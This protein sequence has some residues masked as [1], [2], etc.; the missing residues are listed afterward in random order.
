MTGAEP[1]RVLIADDNAIIRQGVR[2]LLESTAPDIEVVAEAVTGREAI[3]RARELRPTVALLDIRMPVLDGVAAAEVISGLAR[4]LMLTYSDDEPMVVGAIRAGAAGYLVHGRFQAPELEAAIRAVAAGQ[5]AISPAVAPVVLRALRHQ[6]T[7]AAASP[8]D[9]QLTEREHEVMALIARGHSNRSI[10]AELVIS[11]KTVKNHIRH[12][13]EKLGVASRTQAIAQWLGV[14]DGH[15]RLGDE[16]GQIIPLLVLV[17]FSVLAIGVALFAVGQASSL[18]AQGQTAA[19]AGAL[20][21]AKEA[22][23]ESVEPHIGGFGPGA[24]DD[25]RVRAAAADAARRNGGELT[26]YRRDGYTVSVVV[27]TRDMVQGPPAGSTGRRAVARASATLAGYSG[28]GVSGSAGPTSGAPAAGVMVPPGILVGG[29]AFPIQPV[30]QAVGPSGWSLDQGVDVSTAGGACGPA[31]VEVAVTSGTIVEEGI[32]GFGPYAPVLRIDSGPYANWYAYYGHA[33][34]ALV[35]VGTHVRAGQPIAEV[36]CGIVGLSSGPHIE[37]GLTPP[38]QT[39]CCPS[40][41]ETAPIAATLLS[42]IYAH[43]PPGSAPAVGGNVANGADVAG[44][45]PFA[46]HLVPYA[47]P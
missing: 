18:A 6:A 19:D 32:S 1:I 41:G 9:G 28:P 34:P 40:S 14:D 17:L 5:T 2:S 4:V 44:V 37:F 43:S 31:A 47:G 35:P 25:V 27:R 21:G 13:Y 3:N 33:A 12:I 16:S 39:L 29:W 20:G 8:S 26:D 10:A 30:G 46:I 7:S 23:L 36:G 22:E 42:Q 24:I 11:E 45:T 38:G 15:A